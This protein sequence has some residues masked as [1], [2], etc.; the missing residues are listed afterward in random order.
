MDNS[1]NILTNKRTGT[2]LLIGA[3]L[4]V[5]TML[6]HPQGVSDDGY[7][8]SA[9]KWVH[10]GLMLVLVLNASG[11]ACLVGFFKARS[12][13]LHLGML[14]YYIGLGS[15]IG[16]A[17][18]SGFVQTSLVHA[19]S[20]DTETFSNF[21]KFSSIFNQSLAKLGMISFGAAGLCL[22]PV[23]IAENGV[24]RLV[25]ITGCVVGIV[26]ILSILNG[27]YLS[28]LNMTILAIFVAIWH[29]AIAI[30]LI[31]REQ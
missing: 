3:F 30:W 2:L 10:G 31:K 5:F 6:Q 17:L 22:G 28:V 11:L 29:V 19:F 4:T 21:N 27:F 18:V 23:L 25:G 8:N 26:L 7:Q 9:I 16:A 13:D 20:V 15:I 14:F 1:S 12:R 24:S